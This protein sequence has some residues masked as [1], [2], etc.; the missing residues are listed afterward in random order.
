MKKIFRWLLPLSICLIMPCSSLLSD[1]QANEPQRIEVGRE[2]PSHG[3]KR[4][5]ATQKQPPQTTL[6]AIAKSPGQFLSYHPTYYIKTIGVDGNTVTLT[7]ETVWI[8]TD[9]SSYTARR[10]MKDS[11]VVLTP[12][13]WFSRYQ[14]YIVNKMT[15]E[16]ITAK[17]SQGPFL[18]YAILI[19]YIDPY[20]GLVY[21][22]NGTR[23][24]IDSGLKF[25]TWREQQAV[26]IGENNSFFGK[27]YI[28]I[29]INENTYLPASLLP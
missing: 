28:L 4:A 14:Y 2:K 1:D 5:K 22:S 6:K 13:G 21:L 24:H 17:L 8:I 12:S 27:P 16:T 26:L 19:D 25:C 9:S 3:K 29:N 18:K 20:Q 11:P 15:N 7:D 10:W 23:W